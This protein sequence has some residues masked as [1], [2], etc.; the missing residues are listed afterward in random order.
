[1]QL[2]NDNVIEALIVRFRFEGSQAD[3]VIEP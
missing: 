3:C 1:M 2:T